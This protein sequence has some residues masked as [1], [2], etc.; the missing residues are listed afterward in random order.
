MRFILLSAPL[1]LAGCAAGIAP[2]APSLLPRAIETRSDAEPV[3]TAPIVGTDAA[4]DARI[5]ERAAKFD[6][7]AKAFVA[8]Q[9][10]LTSKI[11]RAKGAVE[12]SDRWLEG[13]SAIGELQ[14][15]RTA[16]DGAMADLEELAIERASA[17]NPPY[18]ALEAAIATA[19]VELNRQAAI[20]ARLKSVLGA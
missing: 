20:E 13:Q 3:V 4:L 10:A 5:A 6:A 17:G 1:I 7:A 15:A 2:D 8:V 9:P 19:Q 11:E 14:Q 12:G 16:S 18:P